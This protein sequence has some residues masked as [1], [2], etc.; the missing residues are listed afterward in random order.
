MR[1]GESREKTEG[2]RGERQ[3]W[4][5]CTGARDCGQEEWL[6]GGS[7]SLRTTLVQEGEGMPDKEDV[8]L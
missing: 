3:G 7:R 8:G 5:D 2:R 6:Q 1:R 4:A